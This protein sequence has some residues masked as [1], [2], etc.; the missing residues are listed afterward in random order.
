[1]ATYIAGLLKVSNMIY[2]KNKNIVKQLF[3]FT[4]KN[5]VKLSST[6]KNPAQKRCRKT[7]E[8]PTLLFTGTMERVA[9]THEEGVVT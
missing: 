3:I 1:M 8:T 9:S 7:S 2:R 5:V 4:N 6:P